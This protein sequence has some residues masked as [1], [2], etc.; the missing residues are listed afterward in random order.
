[1]FTFIC[2]W[3]DEK[4]TTF[5]GLIMSGVR[6]L[7]KEMQ[8]A[9]DFQSWKSLALKLD[10]TL[11]HEKWKQNPVSKDYDYRLIARNLNSLKSL[12]KDASARLSNLTEDLKKREDWP[13]SYANGRWIPSSPISKTRRRSTCASPIGSAAPSSII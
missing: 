3:L 9:T 8:I 6:Q 7:K 1:M 2:R 4:W 10:S 13:L 11:G 12:Q 5:I